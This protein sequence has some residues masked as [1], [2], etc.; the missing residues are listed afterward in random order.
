MHELAVCQGLMRQIELLAQREQ[1]ECITAIRLSIGPLSGVEPQLLADA[2]P[3][4]SAG[5]IAEG[6]TLE[7]ESQPIRVRCLTCGAES[8]ATMNNLVCGSCGD[9]RTQLL[10]GDELLLTSVEL[11]RRQHA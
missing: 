2:F 5:S 11:E 7:I 3:I 9:F 8:D 1:A 4:A 10:S 6:A